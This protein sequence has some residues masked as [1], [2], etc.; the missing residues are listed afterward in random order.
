MKVLGITGGIGSGKSV[1]CAILRV[2]GVPVYDADQEAKKVYE[3]SPELLDRIRKEFSEEVFDKNGRIDKKKMADLIFSNPEKL[4]LLNSW[5]H[6]LVRKDFQKWC[7]LHEDAHYVVKEAAILFES[8]AYK[9]CDQILSVLSPLELRIQRIRERDRKTRNE[10]ERIIENQWSDEERSKRSDFIVQ[11]DE[12]ELLIPQ[13][14]Q[15]HE[16]LVKEFSKTV[17]LQKRILKKW[18]E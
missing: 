6:P 1:V 8:G 17:S 16:T 13:I 15:I 7:A 11:N 4:K 9:D 14:L 5:V 12:N 2:L 18:P 10:V 3:K